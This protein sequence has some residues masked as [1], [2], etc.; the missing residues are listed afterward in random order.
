MKS[1]QVNKSLR[2]VAI[3]AMLCFG[4]TSGAMAVESVVVVGIGSP[5]T[6]ISGVEFRRLWLGKTDRVNDVK[7][8]PFESKDAGAVKDEFCSQILG[9]TSAEIKKYFIKEA[10]AGGAKPPKEV[11]DF[12]ALMSALEGSQSAISFM[13]KSKVDSKKVKIIEVR[14]D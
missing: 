7:L 9:K 2:V 1:F 11:T 13:D 14:K 5:L 3:A 12:N 4:A 8:E 6:S 10:L